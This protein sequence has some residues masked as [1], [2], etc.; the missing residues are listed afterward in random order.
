MEPIASTPSRQR[1][2]PSASFKILPASA[3]LGAEVHGIDLKCID[4]GTF[5]ALHEAWLDN[6]ML[7][8]RDQ[9][10]AA[11]DLVTLVQRFGSP[12]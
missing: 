2:Q 12:V 5:E 6:V 3:A 4:E 10:M 7:V 1:A 11:E 8:F 9:S